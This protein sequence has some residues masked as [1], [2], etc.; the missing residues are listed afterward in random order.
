M[1]NLELK[2]MFFGLEFEVVASATKGSPGRMYLPNGDPGYPD[3]PG[4]FEMEEAYLSGVDMGE[5]LQCVTVGELNGWQYLEELAEKEA[6][7]A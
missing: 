3:E 1:T 5:F 4:E 2:V 7:E 6:R